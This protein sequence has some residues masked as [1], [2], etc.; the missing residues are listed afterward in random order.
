MIAKMINR[1][2]V[3][4][5]KDKDSISTIKDQSTIQSAAKLLSISLCKGVVCH[6]LVSIPN[7]Y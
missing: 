6:S 7:Q 4:L 2:E 5:Y 3:A 1:V